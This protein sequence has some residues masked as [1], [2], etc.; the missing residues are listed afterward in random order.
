MN[1]AVNSS[2]AKVNVQRNPGERLEKPIGTLQVNLA[3][4]TRGDR[5]PVSR[6]HPAFRRSTARN[7]EMPPRIPSPFW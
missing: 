3:L 1:K 5:S 6:C 2:V 7:E 4:R